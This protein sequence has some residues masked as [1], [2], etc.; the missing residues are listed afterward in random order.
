LHSSFRSKPAWSDPM[1]ISMDF[2]SF[3]RKV[4]V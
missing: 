4:P 2:E 3:L 1:M